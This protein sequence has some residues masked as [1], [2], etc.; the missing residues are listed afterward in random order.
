MV[1]NAER[2]AAFKARMRAEG[3]QQLTVWATAAQAKAIKAYLE[4]ESLPVTPKQPEKESKPQLPKTR[5]QT[6]RQDQDQ[7]RPAGG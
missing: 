2:Q 4:G 6:C 7:D 3:K 5:D 1:T